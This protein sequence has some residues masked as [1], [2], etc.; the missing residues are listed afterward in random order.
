[1]HEIIY[2]IVTAGIIII[3]AIAIILSAFTD[4]IKNNFNDEEEE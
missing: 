2:W 1:M 3:F 4:I